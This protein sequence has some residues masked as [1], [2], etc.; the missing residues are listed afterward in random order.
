MAWLNLI[1]ILPL[2]LVGILYTFFILALLL[3]YFDNRHI[4]KK[5]RKIHAFIYG[6]GKDYSDIL[7]DTINRCIL[8]PVCEGF[9]YHRVWEKHLEKGHKDYVEH[10]AID[11][12]KGIKRLED[13]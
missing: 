6:D 5:V 4:Y 13:V 10:I 8:C 11:F 12:A 2:V 3:I 7:G 9:V 1:W